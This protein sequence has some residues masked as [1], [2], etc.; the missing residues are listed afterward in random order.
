GQPGVFDADASASVCFTG[1]TDPASGCLSRS[2]TGTSGP[3]GNTGATKKYVD[4]NI[5]VTPNDINEV[6]NPHTFTV[7]VN[8][9]VDAT[10]LTPSSFAITPAVVPTPD[11]TNTNTCASP[12]VS[13]NGLTATC[14]IT[15]NNSQPGVFDA[16]AS[17]SVCFAG[18]THR[19]GAARVRRTAGRPGH[20][21]NTAGK[22]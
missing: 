5:K 19:A 7:E 22:P 20:G 6:N 8:A 16:D 21:G 3:G 1:L 15:I 11:T 13:A 12:T 18:L 10:G 9:L 2:T 14:T 17:A 4:A